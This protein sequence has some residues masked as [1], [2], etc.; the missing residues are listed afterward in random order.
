[1]KKYVVASLVVLLFSLGFVTAM[2]DGSSV[3]LERVLASEYDANN[4][5]FYVVGVSPEGDID[6]YYGYNKNWSKLQEN[7][8]IDNRYAPDEFVDFAIGGEPDEAMF[9]V[10]VGNKIVDVNP[11]NGS[12]NVDLQPRCTSINGREFSDKPYFGDGQP[13]V[14]ADDLETCLSLDYDADNNIYVLVGKNTSGEIDVYWGQHGA[15]N[16]LQENRDIDNRYAPDEF[17]DFSIGAEAGEAMYGVAVGNKI[18]DIN[19]LNGSSNVDLQPRCTSINAREFSDKPYFGDGSPKVVADNLETCLSID[20]DVENNIYVL[21]GVN[22]D[23]Q[24][25]VYW[26]Q[27]GAWNQL[28][29]NRDIDN[30]YAPSQF[31]DMTIG[32][33]TGK[34]GHNYAL[35]IGNKDRYKIAWRTYAE[36]GTSING[37]LFYSKP[38]FGDGKA[39]AIG[40]D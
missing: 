19:P 29:E 22:T 31:V 25:D 38:Y 11:L 13:Q 24:I 40:I 3:V 27:D 16:K 12:A 36:R 39:A 35:V 4:D 18:V 6:V 20:Y 5:N 17:V 23:G 15:W 10:V 34:F 14:V 21:V 32:L 26:G 9:A 30:R 33:P 1:M 8:D 37:R 7:R 28:Q 2:A